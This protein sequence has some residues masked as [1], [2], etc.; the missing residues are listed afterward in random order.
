M[1]STLENSQIRHLAQPLSIDNYHRLRDWGVL[2][3]KI[4]LIQGVLVKKMSKSPLH[5]YVVSLLFA[6]LAKNLPDDYCLRKEEPLTLADSEPEPDLSLVKGSVLDFRATHPHTAELII[7]VAVSTLAMDRE[8][9]KLYAGANVPI[10]WLVDVS[11][12]QVEVYTQPQ[13][14]AYQQQR[15]ER[16]RLQTPFGASLPISNLFC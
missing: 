3:S 9:A 11:A 2:D 7:E 6:F 1:I 13:A 15:L 16:N 10:Y 5:T 14:G 4:E 8:K 12:L